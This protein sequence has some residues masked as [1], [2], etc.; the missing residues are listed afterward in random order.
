[1]YHMPNMCATYCRKHHPSPSWCNR[2]LWS[3]F[4]SSAYFTYWPARLGDA[5]MHALTYISSSLSYSPL[6][7]NEWPLP[8]YQLKLKVG[9]HAKQNTAIESTFGYIFPRAQRGCSL[10]AESNLAGPLIQRGKPSSQH[11]PL[12]DMLACI[13]RMWCF[14][15]NYISHPSH[16][17]VTSITTWCLNANY[18]SHPLYLRQTSLPILDAPDFS[19][20]EL[21]KISS[22]PNLEIWCKECTRSMMQYGFYFLVLLPW[23]IQAH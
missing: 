7:L 6:S 13:Q 20:W 22:L 4:S 1:M 16:L 8:L 11:K 19:K 17:Y 14:N 23:G 10:Y 5:T 15:V 18:I 3:F 2:A 12:T 21:R 9:S